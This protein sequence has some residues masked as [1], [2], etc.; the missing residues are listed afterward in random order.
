MYTPSQS[1]ELFSW[2]NGVD[3]ISAS[4]LLS[5]PFMKYFFTTATEPSSPDVRDAAMAKNTGMTF[6]PCLSISRMN[7]STCLRLS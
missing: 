5:V 3:R 1:R 4:I 2:E 6:I 7:S